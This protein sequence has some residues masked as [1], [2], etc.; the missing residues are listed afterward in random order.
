VEI[1]TEGVD[2]TPR[3]LVDAAVAGD[4]DAF[5]QLV[6]PHLPVALGAAAILLRSRSDADDAVQDALLSAWQGLHRLRDP[7]AFPAWFRQ[8]VVRSAMR[9][10]RRIGRVLELDVDVAAPPGELE[11]AVERRLLERAFAQLAPDDR[12]LLTLR[13]YWGMPVAEVAGLLGVPEGTVRSRTHQAMERLRAAYAA[14]ER[15]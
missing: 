4:R 10:A 11:R 2:V 5:R 12:L 6:E 15:R 8:H 1:V 14:E 13:H 3:S 7:A 9:R